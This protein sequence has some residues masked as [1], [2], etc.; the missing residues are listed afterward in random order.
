MKPQSPVLE[1]LARRYERRQA[2]RTGEAS[3]DV[4]MD[5]EDLLCDA[6]AAEGELRAVAEQQLRAAEQLGI[7]K[8]DPLDRRDRSSLHQVRFSPSNEVKLY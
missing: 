5:V 4:L 3:R 2:G 7:L 8:L 6:G 1:A